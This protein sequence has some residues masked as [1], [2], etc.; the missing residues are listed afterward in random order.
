MG[1]GEEWTAGPR[2]YYY[3]L[4]PPLWHSEQT[5]KGKFG[6]LEWERMVG[7]RRKGAELGDE[8]TKHV[9]MAGARELWETP[10]ALKSGD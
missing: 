6:M 7:E 10:K 9:Y 2:Q 3:R 5:E 8:R 1:S 4:A